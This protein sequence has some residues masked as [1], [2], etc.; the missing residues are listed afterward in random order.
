[1]TFRL[2]TLLLLLLS[3]VLPLTTHAAEAPAEREPRRVEPR[4]GE[5]VNFS[6]LDYRGK[7]YELRRADARVVVL[8]F[9]SFGCPIARQSVPKLRALR[10]QFSA[11][12]VEFWLVNSSPQDDPDESAL[13][14]LARGRGRG[15]MP[16][17][18]L[19]DPDAL[20]SEILKAIVGRMPILR[21]E[22]QLV[23]QQLGVSRTCEVIAIDTKKLAIIYR[24]AVDDQFS[25]GAQK[26]K[27]TQKFLITAL[28]EFLAGKPV[29]TPSAPVHGCRITFEIEPA[30]LPISYSGQI[31]PLLQKHCV[32][33][34][35]PGNIGPFAM[36]SY[37][38][39]KGWSA[40]IEEVLLDRRMP[41]WHA[42]PHYGKF[43]NDRSLTAAEAHTLRRWIEQGSPRGEGEDPLTNA[44][45]PAVAWQLGQ[46]DFIVALP[47][48]EEIPATGTLNYRYI[49]A[50]FVMP[51]DAWLRAAVCRAGNARVVH[52]I[53]VRVRY[54]E[55]Y[56]DAPPEAFL[57]TSWVPGLAQNEFPAGTGMFL[58]K[59]TKFNFELHYTTNGEE[60]TDQSE[61]GLYLA[62]EP[63][64]RQLEVRA[65]ET[66]E[67]ELA[68]GDPDA[69]HFS[70]YCFKRDAI[71]Y[72]LSPHMHL[73]GSWFKFQL[74]HPDG[75]RETLLSVPQYDF[76]WQTSYRLAEPR[77]VPAGT[78]M[79]CTGGHDNSAKNPNNPDPAKRIRWGLQ[80]W[81]EMFMGFMTVADAPAEPVAKSAGK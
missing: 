59:G 38:K 22:R 64:K 45:P 36:S 21:D 34:H 35:S 53:I 11:S 23:A 77:R 32:G 9:T 51:Q 7:Y 39:V 75:R 42:D 43:V 15:L 24:G 72:S 57:F 29:T 19:A 74:L 20:R 14:A 49:D 79:L 27:P 40:M 8:F 54:P 13:E 4:S 44:P 50:D 3:Q 63:A 65:S 71:L 26:P 31:A 41:P 76:N 56:K 2:N 55:S 67:F 6:L 30:T 73:R 58:P 48:P 60:Q 12:G 68:P 17:T 16:E 61:L 66:R 47:K 10:N 25:E 69:Q 5:V 28:E 78:W 62:K 33:C 70:M 46:P 18:A 81:D 52:H 1:M 37:H 80:S